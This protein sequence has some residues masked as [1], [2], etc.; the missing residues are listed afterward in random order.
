MT[1][2]LWFVF[3]L[4]MGLTVAHASEQA[5]IG[6]G[7][8][9]RGS[10]VEERHLQGFRGPMRSEGQF[11]VAPSHGLIWD[12]EKP[13]PSTTIITTF[14]LTQTIQGQ[15]VTHLSAQKIP[16]LLHLYDMLGGALAGSWQPLEAD[17]K[18]VQTEDEAGWRAVLTPRQTDNLAMPY[19]TITVRGHRFVEQV[20]LA[21]SDGDFDTIIFSDPALSQRPLSAA[22]NAAFDA[23]KP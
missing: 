16:F 11:T 2:S 14:G 20:V 6:T 4:A 21:K 1:R 3:F 10:F 8:I 5:A 13:F 23:V 9:L 7:D 15:Q 19:N 18:V 12:V 22:E 17:F